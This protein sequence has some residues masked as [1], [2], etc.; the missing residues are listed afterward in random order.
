MSWSLGKAKYPPQAVWNKLDVVSPPEILPNLNR[1]EKVLTSRIILFKKVNIMLKGRFPKLKRS[2]CNIPIESGDITSVLP[3][4]AD[5]NGLLIAKLK[6]KLS[7]RCHVYFEA[8][9]PELIC[10]A[11]MYLKQNNSLYYNIGIALENIP[12]DLLSLSESSDNHQEIDKSDTLEEDENPQ[13]LHRFSSE[14]TMFVPNIT[15]A[16]EISIDPGEGKESTSILNDKYCEELAFPCLF[17]KRKFGHKVERKIKLSPVKYFNQHLLNY[18]QIFAAD[19]DYIFFALY[20]T[21]QLKL[22]SQINIAM[23]KVCSGHLTAGVLSQ[24]ISEKVKSFI[25]NN[26]A[27]H[28]MNTLKV[29]QLTGKCYFMKFLQW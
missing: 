10:Q 2:I 15:T 20:L 4:G 3:C 25:V 29:L 14:E 28:F 23:K 18:T 13:D 12:N 8:V 11:L 1:L 9:R 22:Q 19:P 17:P 5:S 24:K 26:E 6:R 27:Y 16:E 7:Y 21:Q